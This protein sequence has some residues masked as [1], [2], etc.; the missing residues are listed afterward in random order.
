[1]MLWHHKFKNFSTYLCL[2]LKEGSILY[3]CVGT[4]WKSLKISWIKRS[5]NT[6]SFWKHIL[7]I[8]LKRINKRI[9][10]LT[11]YGNNDF[12]ILGKNIHNQFW[13]GVFDCTAEML[14]SIPF[15][16]FNKGLFQVSGNTLFKIDNRVISH[17]L[18]EQKFLQV[19]NFI[20]NLYFLLLFFP[21]IQ[22]Y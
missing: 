21:S 8:D 14:N 15:H 11:S 3:I 2:K 10:C 7:D 13:K 5:Q 6:K 1:M 9:D 19:Y 22:M 16:C 18:L 17:T 4:F 20:D 12:I